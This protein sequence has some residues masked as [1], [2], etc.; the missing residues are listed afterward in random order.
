MAQAAAAHLPGGHGRNATKIRSDH[1]DCYCHR[2]HGYV[3]H[4][5]QEPFGN[6]GGQRGVHRAAQREAALHPA[7]RGAKLHASQRDRR[8]AAFDFR[9]KHEWHQPVQWLLH[10]RHALHIPQHQ[11]YR[12]SALGRLPKAHLQHH[13]VGQRG[14]HAEY[15][16][17]RLQS[18]APN[19]RPRMHFLPRK[20]SHPIPP[21]TRCA[22]TTTTAPANP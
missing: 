15:S 11:H 9:R 8:S 4:A 16:R 19:V 13:R 3:R 1:N 12:R 22:A 20:N 18:L 17:R 7:V 10:H 2:L 21:D 14:R 6:R 5:E